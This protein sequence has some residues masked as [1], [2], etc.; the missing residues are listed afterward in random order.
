MRSRIVARSG[1]CRRCAK[2][3]D[4]PTSRSWSGFD[5]H[6]HPRPSDPKDRE[7]KGTQ[8]VNLARW[9][10]FF[11]IGSSALPGSPSLGPHAAHADLAGDDS[12][13]LIWTFPTLPNTKLSAPRFV[14][15][16]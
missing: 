15:L 4:W 13:S 9:R 14:H 11:E 5:L 3:A 2:A 16:P 7:G 1:A 12:W 8:A 6:C 10:K